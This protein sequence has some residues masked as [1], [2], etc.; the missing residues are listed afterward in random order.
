MPI[1]VLIVDDTDTVRMFQRM[2]LMAAGYELAEAKDG[3]QALD[4]VHRFQPDVILLDVNMPVLDGLECCRRL[5]SSSETSAIPVIVVTTRGFEAQVKEAYDAGCDD[6]VTKP[7]RK[8]ELLA[9]IKQ[10]VGH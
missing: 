9:K 2:T 5:K 10:L 4:A 3:L 6:Y 8:I 7:I 1:R